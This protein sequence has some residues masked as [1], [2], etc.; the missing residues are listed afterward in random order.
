MNLKENTRTRDVLRALK[1]IEAEKGQ[2]YVAEKLNYK[3]YVT[4]FYWHKNS[5]I[6]R[7]AKPRVVSFINQESK[8]K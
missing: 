4:I 2:K 8:R 1:R 6:P 7:L 3:T 5:N